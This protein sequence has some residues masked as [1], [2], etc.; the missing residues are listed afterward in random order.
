MKIKVFDNK[1]FEEIIF[2]FFFGIDL[3]S[4]CFMP[5]VIDLTKSSGVIMTSES[6]S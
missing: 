6:P 1:C 3:P 5:G 2:V 4:G